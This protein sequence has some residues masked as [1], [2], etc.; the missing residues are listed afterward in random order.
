MDSGLVHCCGEGVMLSDLMLGR[1]AIFLLVLNLA[2]SYCISCESRLNKANY[3][4]L[5]T[6]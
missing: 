4:A 3:R 5:Y 1:G 6:E 2:L